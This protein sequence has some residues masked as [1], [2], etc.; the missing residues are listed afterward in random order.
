[1]EPRK[2]IKREQPTSIRIIRLTEEVSIAEQNTEN[3]FRFGQGGINFR[4]GQSGGIDFRFGQGG[5]NFRFA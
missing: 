5:I 3:L 2:R 4:F 1:M